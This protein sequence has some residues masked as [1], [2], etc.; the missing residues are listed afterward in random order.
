M[1]KYFLLLVWS[2]FL[3]FYIFLILLAQRHY[4]TFSITFLSTLQNIEV[5]NSVK[6]LSEIPYIRNEDHLTI[7]LNLYKGKNSDKTI[8]Y[9]ANNFSKFT[10]IYKLNPI[11]NLK[12]LNNYI[13]LNEDIV[14]Q[15]LLNKEV[16]QEEIFNSIYPYGI[17]FMGKFSD[18]D[19]N[20]EFEISIKELQ[21]TTDKNCE[22][23]QRN[24]LNYF[25]KFQKLNKSQKSEILTKIEIPLKIEYLDLFKDLNDDEKNYIFNQSLIYIQN[26]K[27]LDLK[28][29]SLYFLLK[30]LSLINSKNVQNYNREKIVI[31]EVLKTSTYDREKLLMY[32][33]KHLSNLVN[34]SPNEKFEIV[35]SIL[36]PKNTKYILFYIKESNLSQNNI[37]QIIKKSFQIKPENYFLSLIKELEEN[38]KQ[39][40]FSKI[41]EIRFKNEFTELTFPDK[42]MILRIPKFADFFKDY[43][44]FCGFSFDNSFKLTS[45]VTFEEKVIIAPVNFLTKSRNC[46]L[47]SDTIFLSN[48]KIIEMYNYFKNGNLAQF[49]EKEGIIEPKFIV[50]EILPNAETK[51]ELRIVTS[52]EFG[53]T[54]QMIPDYSTSLTDETFYD[55]EILEFSIIK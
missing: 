2:I 28:S 55:N 35:Y 44:L 14:E 43:E 40:I 8:P 3:L 49:S 45:I 33:V 18:F 24:F 52:S 13:V 23:K 25:K 1:R 42:N 6:N 26:Q 27:D 34:I 16:S 51:K 31:N 29:N 12:I 36:N 11:E 21:C 54:L 9:L 7:F 50:I 39:E 37:Q 38:D 17:S 10:G 47:D 53:R 20:K 32:F 4:K 19:A 15:F 41:Q 48:E 22:S 46:N 30:N 5:L